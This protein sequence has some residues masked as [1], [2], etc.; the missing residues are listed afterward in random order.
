MELNCFQE[1]NL[2]VKSLRQVIREYDAA[3]PRMEESHTTS[4]GS[5][6]NSSGHIA[7]EIEANG[8]KNGGLTSNS[9]TDSPKS[10]VLNMRVT[11][12]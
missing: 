4:E 12:S 7:Q 3:S 8:N 1:A 11:F 2:Y 9:N 6:T 5:T 10:A